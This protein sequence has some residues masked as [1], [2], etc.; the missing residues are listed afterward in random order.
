MAFYENVY[1]AG[2]V[3]QSQTTGLR[4]NDFS[5][6]AQVN[7]Q[8]DRHG[9][10]LERMEVQENFN[11]EVG[12]LRR[13]DFRRNYAE[14]RFSP[15]T[16]SSRFVRRRVYQ[17]HVEYTTDNRNRLE[18]RELSA[19]FE[20]EFHNI[21][22][23][24]FQYFSQ[25]E[26]VPE[27]FEIAPDVDIPVG[28][29]DFD[30]LKITYLAGQQHR[31]SGTSTLEIG[32]FYGGNKTTATYRGRVEIT[33]Q[34]GLEPNISLNWIDLPQGKFTTT[35][36]GGRGTYTITPQM[37]VAALV[38]YS[39]SNTSLATNLR[40]RW[41]YQPGSEFFVVYTEGRSTFPPR[42]TDLQN[43]GVVVKVNRLFRF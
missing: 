29:Y 38:Q 2:Y 35:V 17:G 6:R 7:Y 19:L 39:S 16:T 41:E 11:P 31:L 12:F 3:A 33:P 1:V 43:R 30:N 13:E 14:V 36:I 25:F 15:R 42:G 21:D 22:S 26:F 27:A 10:V 32:S 28:E 8:G 24:A 40:F 37:F 9:L 34:L 4:G 23:L 18:T 20:T 5:Y